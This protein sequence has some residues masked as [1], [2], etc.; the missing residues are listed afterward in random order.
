MKFYAEEP[1]AVPDLF[2]RSQLKRA[3]ETGAILQST[4]LYFDTDK[5][6]HFRLGGFAALMPYEECADGILT[7]A[8]RDIAIITRVGRAACFIIKEF[9]EEGDEPLLVLSRAAAQR[10]CKADY[11]ALL[12]PGDIIPCT[13]THI[14]SFGVF[15]DVGCGISALLPI[16]CLSVSRISSPA[17]RVQIGE[18]LLCAVRTRDAQGR[19]VLSMKELL[20]TWQQNAELFHVGMS[21][22]GTVRSIEEY[23]VFVEL[24]PNL[25]GLAEYDD[26][27][28]PGD[29]V[30]VYIKSILPDKMKVKLV[31]LSRLENPDV[32]PP[33][34][35]FITEGH[36]EHWVY[37]TQNA[38]KLI[39][40]NF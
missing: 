40:T 12:T 19:L 2:T 30:S 8:V 5:S 10:R 16:D 13:A 1:A 26:R 7:G 32:P 38:K 18:K 35:L 9:N 33:L 36:L 20:G 29:A 14:E 15:C 23:G 3:F 21:V 22:T 4:A 28:S 6:L 31:L 27:L 37:S 39:E 34:R 24:A 25:A 17:D 11:L